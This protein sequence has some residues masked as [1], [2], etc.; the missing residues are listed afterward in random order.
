VLVDQILEDD[1]ELAGGNWS[2]NGF[3]ILAWNTVK[4]SDA[5]ASLSE[6]RMLLIKTS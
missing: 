1:L 5:T 6:T 3:E 4:L 2:R